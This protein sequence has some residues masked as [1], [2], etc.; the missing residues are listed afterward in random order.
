[1]VVPHVF[2]KHFDLLLVENIF[3]FRVCKCRNKFSRVIV[4][5]DPLEIEQLDVNLTSVLDI[6]FILVLGFK[7]NVMLIFDV[8]IKRF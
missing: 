6:V 7:L 2:D 1:V 8:P 3:I 5:E 4:H